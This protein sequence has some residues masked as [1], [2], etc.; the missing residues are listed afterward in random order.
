M[1]V[2]GRR[3]ALI[4]ELSNTVISFQKVDPKCQSR[5]L[6]IIAEAQNAIENAKS[7]I[8]ETI[9]RNISPNRKLAQEAVN[10]CLKQISVKA[11]TTYKSPQNQLEGEEIKSSSET[12]LSNKKSKYVYDRDAMMEIRKMVQ[13]SPSILAEASQQLLNKD[14]DILC[15]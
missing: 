8:A 15:L 11:I 12:T 6:T 3:V 14:L 7:L 1:G 2:K 10:E 9:E 5:Q 4:E 13:N